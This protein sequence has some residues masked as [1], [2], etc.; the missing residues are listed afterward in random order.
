MNYWKSHFVFNKS[1]R[2][3]IFILFIL[4]VVLQIIYFSYP[5]F[6]AEEI[7]SEKLNPEIQQFQHKLDSL[8]Q[9]STK[10]DTIYPFNPNYLTDFKAYSL[11]MSVNEI[12]RLLKY[13]SDGNWINS[14]E[15]FQ[16]IT[17]VSDSV[18]YK[19]SPHFKFPQWVAKN[20]TSNS[21]KSPSIL[22]LDINS[23][24]AEQLQQVNGI[25]E[26][27]SNRIVRYRL[28][29][30]GYRS[31]IQLKDIYGLSGEVRKELLKYLD[32][33][34]FNFERKNINT[35][36]VLELSE[37]PYFDYELAKAVIDYRNL[38]EGIQ[39]IEVLSKIDDFPTSKIDRIQLYLSFN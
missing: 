34:P 22:K 14:T 33:I 8:K 38:H 12:D 39:S 26:V 23:V 29:I 36:R 5:F 13:R 15:D 9:A 28:S 20:K 18:L 17:G 1:E 3:G 37:L 11:G 31:L 7:T 32:E 16:T 30:G 4:I 19:L 21:I 27:L 2:N 6:I 10:K 24:S 35:I 25:G